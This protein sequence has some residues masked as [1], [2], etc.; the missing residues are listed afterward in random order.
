MIITLLLAFLVLGAGIA[1][2][3]A[4]YS[5]FFDPE[6]AVEEDLPQTKEAEEAADRFMKSLQYPLW[7]ESEPLSREEISLLGR[8]PEIM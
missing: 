6:A 4:V 5:V 8:A 3:P 1:G 2:L 7:E